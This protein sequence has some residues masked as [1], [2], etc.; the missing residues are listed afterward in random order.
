MVV[1][2]AKM[3]SRWRRW[4]SCLLQRAKGVHQA[5]ATTEIQDRTDTEETNPLSCDQGQAGIGGINLC[6]YL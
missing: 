4:N 2:G 1:S 5:P 6:A 3:T